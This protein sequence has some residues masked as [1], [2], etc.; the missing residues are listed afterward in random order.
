MKDP[1][2]NWET[3]ELRKRVTTLEKQLLEIEDERSKW[4]M[5]ES[6]LKRQVANL[7]RDNENLL[8]RLRWV[9]ELSAN[10]SKNP[11]DLAIRQLRPGQRT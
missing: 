1:K 7:T 4:G 11:Y 5:N 6:A 10:T 9:S 8:E 3:I 2:A